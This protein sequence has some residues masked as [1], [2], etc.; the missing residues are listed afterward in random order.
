MTIDAETR[1]RELHG[2]GVRATAGGRPGEGARDLRA[3]LRALGWTAGGSGDPRPPPVQPDPVRD[4]LAARL[5]LSLAH[6]ESEQ[7]R[8]PL[9]F[10]L[11]DLA[12]TVMDPA[13]EG[14]LLQQRGLLLL[15]AGR[16]DE[17]LGYLNQAEPKLAAHGHGVV[18]ARTLLN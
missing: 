14:V 16:L 9:G 15:R 18:L 6:A 13:D 5:L 12:A 7:G 17:A 10:R 2:A 3:G 8:G 4:G 1:A 11:L